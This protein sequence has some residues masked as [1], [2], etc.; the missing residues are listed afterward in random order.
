MTKQY[1][2]NNIINILSAYEEK[3]S[4]N[5]SQRQ[6]SEELSV[7]RKT[8]ED[9]KKRRDSIPLDKEIVDFLESEVGHK[10]IH[11][12]TTALIFSMCEYGN[13][14]IR[15]VRLIMQLMGLDYFVASSY[16]SL[17]KQT[18]KI[19]EQICHFGEDQ[20]KK[21][22]NTMP[23]Q[24]ITIA[25]D[26]NFHEKICLVGIEPV[27][28]YILLEKR[29][30][31]LS[32]EIWDE[33]I[34]KAISG[35]NVTVIQA[36]SDQGSSLVKHI[37]ETL[38]AH[39]SPDLFHVKQ[40]FCKAINP[41]LSA[42]ESKEEKLLGELRDKSRKNNIDLSDEIKKQST[43]V[44]EAKSNTKLV[45]EAENAISHAYHPYDIYTG[46]V[47]SVDN[48]KSSLDNSFKQIEDIANKINLRDTGKDLLKK[49]KKMIP[50]MTETLTFF[51]TTINIMLTALNITGDLL[52]L[53]A[54]ILIPIAYLNRSFRKAKDSHSRNKIKVAIENMEQ[55][56]L[57]HPAW[58]MLTDEIKGQ[59]KK[60]AY[61]CADVFQRSSSCVEG[62]NGYLSLRHHGLHNI[63]DRKLNVLT[64]IHNYFIQRDDKTTAAER[65]FKQKHDNLF[66]NL[67]EN[68]PYSARSRK[69]VNDVRKAA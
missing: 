56:L 34:E 65:F 16:E 28:N 1:A 67:V 26:E 60:A 7:P 57:N 43:K 54:E 36:A 39:H 30:D 62:R 18:L 14:G 55:K 44:S 12:I 59:L 63:S 61:D 42:I 66:E 11:R 48:L 9:W 35:L 20:S 29:T 32:S 33:H 25:E 27:S 13:C 6:A 8:I 40:D 10:F 51:F 22:S 64:V 37:N 2:K 49:A 24:F 15:T 58:L 31:K 68:V 53:M 17:R 52:E 5:L 3:I 45:Q 19:E 50:S 69:A 21:L 38:K 4:N 46:K 47:N 23:H 41:K